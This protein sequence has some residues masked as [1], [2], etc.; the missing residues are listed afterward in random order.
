M[1]QYILELV[2]RTIAFCL[3]GFGFYLLYL[4]KHT[5]INKSQRIFLMNLSF[6]EMCLCGAAVA[7]I[8]L[9]FRGY[10][11]AAY[12]IL[13]MQ[14][15]G[16]SLAYYLLM[17]FLTVDRF[18]EINLNIR[19]PLYCS[20]KRARY[21]MVFVWAA[22][23]THIVAYLAVQPSIGELYKTCSLYF[24][25]VAETCF[26]ITA[27]F[28]YSY[29]YKKISFHK[30][31]NTIVPVR[32]PDDGS[33]RKVSHKKLVGR[34]GMFMPSL[35]ILTFVVFFVIPDQTYFIYTL[36]N[37]SMPKYLQI[38]FATSF[39]LGFVTD[40]IIY[41]FLSRHVKS[42]FWLKVFPVFSDQ[43]T[44][45]AYLTTETAPIQQ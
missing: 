43:P 40:A 17:L 10:E 32:I 12:Q 34:I 26:C 30:R 39:S 21:S 33:K 6:C 18:L 2:I 22:A 4:T 9:L 38:T 28:T 37:K 35:L 29:I 15:T 3:H 36:S 31:R 14:L 20:R 13:I 5:N 25:P 45:M 16:F 1:L 24:Y 41:I 19:Y 44:T 27:V 23:F 7:K 42:V 8:T 11:K